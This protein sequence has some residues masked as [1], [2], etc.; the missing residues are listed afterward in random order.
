MFEDM[1]MANGIAYSKNRLWNGQEKRTNNYQQNTKQKTKDCSTRT[2]VLW[3]GKQ[4][5]FPL[6]CIRHVT[7]KRLSRRTL[8]NICTLE[9]LQ[10]LQIHQFNKVI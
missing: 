1:K 5:L 10:N 2:H 8:V 9:H 3:K 6:S 7:I 4:F